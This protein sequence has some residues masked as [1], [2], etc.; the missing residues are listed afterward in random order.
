MKRTT[1]IAVSLLLIM[2]AVCA[3]HA[4][5]PGKY[6]GFLEGY[7]DKLQ[8]GPKD[9]VKQ[10]WLK[11]GV[12]FTKYNK[13]MLD[14]A[15]FFLA[16]DSYKG[17]DPQDMKERA[18]ALNK[19]VVAVFPNKSHFVGEPGPDVARIRFA[20][21]GLKQSNPGRSAVSTVLPVGLAMNLVK[22]GSG[23]SWTGSGA[24]SMEVMVL[25]SMTNDVIAV[26]VDDRTAGFTDRFSKWGSADEAYKFW[27][28][29]LKQFVDDTRAIKSNPPPK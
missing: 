21:T 19:E 26:A 15:V 9:S 7:Y 6:S 17:I 16:D 29:K 4:D 8:P 1:T 12:D 22:K 20:I 2:F 14:S 23:G 11:P 5:G 27:A 13:A 18:D 10:R 24:T 3:G 28:Q 25:D